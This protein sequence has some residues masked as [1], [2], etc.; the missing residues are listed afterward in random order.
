M[1][2]VY[3]GSVLRVWRVAVFVVMPNSYEADVTRG[4]SDKRNVW[5]QYLPPTRCVC[6]CV[7]ACVRACVCVRV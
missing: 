1:V 7:C 2:C 6:V 4:D 3:D 5:G